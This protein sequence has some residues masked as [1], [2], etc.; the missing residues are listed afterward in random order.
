VVVVVLLVL[1]V[2]LEQ[3]QMVVQVEAVLKKDQAEQQLPI[4]DLM[5][6]LVSQ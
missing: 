4:K 3:V 6:E 1:E 2:T 5:V